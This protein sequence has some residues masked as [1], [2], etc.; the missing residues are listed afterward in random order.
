MNRLERLPVADQ[1]RKGLEEC[2]RHANGEITL[3]STVVSAPDP[4]PEVGSEEVA[5]LRV[6]SGLSHRRTSLAC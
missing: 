5:V 1:I 4:S 6:E 2:L 3:K